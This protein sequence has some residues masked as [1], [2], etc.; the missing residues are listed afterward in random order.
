M[1]GSWQEQRQIALNANQKFFDLVY[2]GLRGMVAIVTRDEYGKLNSERWFPADQVESARQYAAARYDEDVYFS[3][4]SFPASIS[5]KNVSSRESSQDSLCRVVYADADTCDP[6]NFRLTPSI[7]VQTSPGRWHVL[8]VMDKPMSGQLLGELSAKVSTAHA[9]QGCDKHAKDTKILRVPGT[10]NTKYGYPYVIE[11]EYTGFIYTYNEFSAAYDDIVLHNA[12]RGSDS[13]A[14]DLSVYTP[15]QLD[16]LHTYAS[17]CWTNVTAELNAEAELGWEGHGWDNVAYRAACKLSRLAAAN[18]T[19]YSLSDAITLMDD[20]ELNDGEFIASSKLERAVKDTKGEALQL[21]DWA[22]DYQGVILPQVEDVDFAELEDRVDRSGLT[23]WYVSVP[24]DGDANKVVTDF[25]DRCRELGFSNEDTYAVVT[26]S[27]VFKNVS[28]ITPQYLWLL[29]TGSNSIEIEVPDI[30]LTRKEWF[31]IPPFLTQQERDWCLANP[32]WSDEYVEWVKSTGTDAATV[33]QRTLAFVILSAAYGDI[34]FLREHHGDPRLNIY[35]Q[36]LGDSCQP[37]DAKVLTPF[38]WTTMGEIEAGDTVIGRNG[39]PVNVLAAKSIKS[40][41][42]YRVTCENGAFAESTLDHLWTVRRGGHRADQE[43]TIPLS[44]IVSQKAVGQ[45]FYLP[46]LVAPVQYEKRELGMDPYLLGLWLAEGCIGSNY[47]VELSGPEHIEHVLACLPEELT[48]KHY[49]TKRTSFN[50]VRSDV[51]RT[52]PQGPNSVR[53]ELRALNLIDKRQKDRWIPED[54]LYSDVD[55]RLALLQGLMDGDGTVDKH[56]GSC[57]FE[58]V[59][60]QLTRNIAELA[61]S[62]GMKVSPVSEQRPTV[63]GNSVWRVNFRATQEIN[64]FRLTRKAEKVKPSYR[65]HTQILDISFQRT[66]DVRCILVDSDDHMY[67]TDNFVLTHNTLTRKTTAMHRALVV[68]QE[69]EERTGKTVE[70]TSNA[71]SEALTKA[72]AESGDSVKMMWTDEIQGYLDE[73]NNKRYL[74]G[75]L[76]TLAKL[77]DGK[78][79]ASLRIGKESGNVK[80]EVTFNFVGVGIRKHVANTLTTK[81]Y[82]SGLMPRFV[83]AVADPPPFTED[84]MHIEPTPPVR[85]DAYGKYESIGAV[86]TRM[87]KNRRRI[88]EDKFTPVTMSREANERYNLMGKVVSA[89]LISTSQY[90]YLS[91]AALRFG[92]NVRKAAALLA[93]HDGVTVVSEAHMVHAIRQGELWFRDMVRMANEVAATDFERQVDEMEKYII[94]GSRNRRP[95]SDLRNKFRGLRAQDFQESLTNLVARGRVKHDQKTGVIT[96]FVV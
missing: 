2:G 85:G 84:A 76:G 50:I 44:E 5:N 52:G 88:G 80:S 9:A 19:P 94:D 54:Y 25:V 74:A 34:A 46:L 12:V 36:V 35:A 93:L 64:P 53:A 77:Y 31:D 51:T 3:V 29:L 23:Q 59:S 39:E 63:A 68:I 15:E 32:A 24:Q 89:Y 67:V 65:T 49:G 92:T 6:S 95:Y 27:N 66:T 7:I 96:A 70:L 91:A 26:N 16:Q 72:L 10:T 75:F 82:E 13:N 1:A 78:V 90:E 83:W 37:L 86:V 33:Y 8:W 42:V 11:A 61:K 60:E 14:V 45:S 38:G 87:V 28:T 41:D 43:V 69:F 55:D 20:S 73:M 57:R 21:P 81:N 47:N 62:L 40:D 48:V 4:S 30:P 71:T 18:W 56:N 17:T 79:E 22:L 58:C